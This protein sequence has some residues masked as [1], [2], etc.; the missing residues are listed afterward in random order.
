MHWKS[1]KNTIAFWAGLCLC[2]TLGVM[3]LHSSHNARD[4]AK[5]ADRERILSTARAEGGRIEADIEEALVTARALA[6]AL[7]SAKSAGSDLSREMVNLMLKSV[8]ERN[9]NFAGVYTAWEP[10]A[11]DGRDARYTNAPSHDATGRFVPYWNRS[12]E[13]NIVVEPLVGY[14]NTATNAQGGRIGDYYLLPRETRNECII[15]PYL[16]PVQGTKVLMTSLVVPIVVN[17]V[18][19][20]IAGVDL[21]LTFLQRLVDRQKL[22]VPGGRKY[23]VSSKGQIAAAEGQPELAGKT[24]Q[25]VF[26]DDWQ[27]HLDSIRKDVEETGSSGDRLLVLTP[28]RVGE[29][30]TPWA[31]IIT[32]P[33]REILAE[34]D[35]MMWREIGLGVICLCVALL[36]LWLIANNIARPISQTVAVAE[37]I[38]EG[39]LAKAQAA[40]A[41]LLPK[42]LRAAGRLPDGVAQAAARANETGKLI[43]AMGVMTD[44]LASLA[45]QVQQSCVQLVATASEIAQAA[46]RQE[47]SVTDFGE[48][49]VGI[50]TAVRQIT[51]TSQE[52]ARTMEDVQATALATGAL[53]DKG[54]TGLQGM[55]DSMRQLGNATTEIA[56][57]LTAI[58][59]NTKAITSL[60]TTIIK[61]ADQTNLLSLNA[62]IEAEKA[63]EHG[64]GFAVVAREIRRLADQTSVA[65]VDIEQTVKQ[66][67]GSVAAGV[68]EMDKFSRE[69]AT[70]VQVV[71]E[72]SRQLEQ[73]LEQVKLLA[74]RFEAVN[75]GMRAQTQGAQQIN[76][77]MSKLSAGA[78]TSSES[79]LKF[80][81]AAEQ[82]KDSAHVLQAEIAQFKVNRKENGQ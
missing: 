44:K 23:I 25:T 29:T 14:E 24:V 77:A 9:P 58:N 78:R 43:L 36:L 22:A 19:L 15:E 33:E 41:K 40:L 72:I 37:R 53:A 56:A 69:M 70:G 32:I 28:F 62:A 63:G 76:D 59:E 48:L 50:V 39:D 54:R 31:V 4:T 1:I 71:G 30:F 49:T 2:A 51:E 45:G 79:V 5:K 27:I 52:L 17:G 20:G 26:P 66:M 21:P 60:V 46:E 75:Q 65:T 11:F 6:Q 10:N 81:Q 74:P 35:A 80:N 7:A 18:F 73:I 57:K 16:Y 8:L 82:L 13:E 12:Q 34:A 42:R 61:V 55:E 68:M 47:T 3:I 38:A 67:R 64:L